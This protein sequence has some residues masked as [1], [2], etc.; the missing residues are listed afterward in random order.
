[1]VVA[2]L[3][4]PL[5][6]SA[7]TAADAGAARAASRGYRQ[8]HEGA[9]VRELATLLA[10]P[11][12][13]RDSAGIRANADTLSAML[14]RRG[15]TTRLLEV[16]GAPPAVFGEL[17]VP[18]ARRTVVLYAHY[19]GQPVDAR[20][21]TTPPWS[22]TLRTRALGDGGTVI[23]LPTA[24]DARLDPESR[25]Y[26]RSAGDDKASIMAMLAALDA[27]RAA[28]IT[29][30]VNIK[31]LL[32]GEEEAG[33]PHLG[34]I[35]RQN[36]AL[37]SGDVLLLCDG[38]VHPSGKQELVFGVRGVTGLELTV[39]GPTRALHSGHYGNW[40]PNPAVLLSDLIT[41]MRDDDG[42]VKIAH[43]YDDVRPLTATER[44]A[45]AAL[46]S[47]DS[48]LRRSLGLARTEAN[49][50][51]LAE[52]IM[53]PALNVRGIQSGAVGTQAANAVPT[54]ARASFDFRL[55]PA[56]TPQRVRELVNAHLRSRGYFVTS[57]S[58]TMT[59][60]LAHPRVARVQW[61][62]AGYPA[63]R[64]VM[65]LPVSRALIAAVRDGT[66]TVPLVVP[67]MGGSAPAYLFEQAL[68]LPVIIVPVANADDN[69]HAANENLR[70][71]NLWNGIDLYAGVLARL[72]VDWPTR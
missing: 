26:A 10:I 70:L 7:Q 50:A 67:S 48:A 21:W 39:Y 3:L 38:P 44:A 68:H 8:A 4:A 55:V 11:N 56:E 17:G 13:A 22:P 46:P 12:L 43:Y 29:P 71:G 9:I 72:G 59:M 64:T 14:R 41:S 1:M 15:I 27:L 5:P 2:A 58:V 28:H 36:A 32:E 54:E 53:V 63:S 61:D 60:R 57:D 34:A 40:A 19:D 25:I 33:S 30:G 65:D 6:A 37:L 45:I 31:L 62:T 24:P 35:L 49:D 42:H 69:Q 52:R 66:G 23:P 47:S 51:P 20:Q 18:G 16:P